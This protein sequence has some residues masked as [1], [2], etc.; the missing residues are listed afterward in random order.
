VWSVVLLLAIAGPSAPASQAQQQ[1]PGAVLRQVVP[2]PTGHNGYEDFILAAEMV[3]ATRE[4]LAVNEAERPTLLDKRKAVSANRKALLLFRE[5]LKKQI[6]QPRTEFNVETLLPEF[7]LFRELGRLLS[8]QE[9]VN[10]ADGKI[11]AAIDSMRDAILLGRHI[12]ERIL[13]AGLVGIAIEDLALR[14]ISTHLEQLAYD[15]CGDLLEVV[16]ELLSLPDP[17]PGLVRSEMDVTVGVLRRGEFKPEYLSMMGED[18]EAQAAVREAMERNPEVFEQEVRRA[19]EIL[20]QHYAE[21]LA[22]LERPYWE[23][24]LPQ[25][26]ATGSDAWGEQIAVVLVP[27]FSKLSERFTRS[28]ARLRLLAT[29]AAILRYRWWYGAAPPN[30]DVLELGDTAA[31]PYTG[32][33]F[34]YKSGGY[35]Y[36]LYSTGGDTEDGGGDENDVFLPGEAGR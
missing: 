8:I 2:N 18:S 17:L 33:R 5:G 23:R 9:E 32:K 20:E 27:D 29:H 15:D 6:Y 36:K 3:A 24:Q 4:F 31:D 13:I 7:S 26:T 19:A 16:D 14:P 21:L 12:Q 1:E 28:T 30:L 34:I 22:E 10:L 25:L 35:D 11:G